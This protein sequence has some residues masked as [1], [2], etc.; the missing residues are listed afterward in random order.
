M[1]F[2]ASIISTTIAQTVGFSM[3]FVGPLQHIMKFVNPFN[4]YAQ[5][6]KKSRNGFSQTMAFA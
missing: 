3:N 2:L 5:V 4:K 1:R 6:M